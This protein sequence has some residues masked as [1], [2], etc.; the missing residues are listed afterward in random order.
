MYVHWFRYEVNQDTAII[1]LTSFLRNCCRPMIPLSVD[2]NHGLEAVMYNVR[3]DVVSA[4]MSVGSGPVQRPYAAS[5]LPI[6]TT[7]R[8]SHPCFVKKP[9]GSF[10]PH[11][12]VFI[13][14][15]SD[16]FA[17]IT[18]T[19]F[20]MLTSSMLFEADKSNTVL[21]NAVTSSGSR[22]IRSPS[23]SHTVGTSFWNPARTRAS[24]HRGLLKSAPTT[25][26]RLARDNSGKVPAAEQLS[27]TFCFASNTS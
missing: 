3:P 2:C 26:L 5:L 7:E 19:S 24:N 27:N 14:S 17:L 8:T 16:A 13:S 22:Y 25:T 21:D 20:T 15:L 11:F 1:N 4:S 23:A 9:F 12:H 18:A 10:A 6:C